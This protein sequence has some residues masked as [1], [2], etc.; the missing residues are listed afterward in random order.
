M[1]TANPYSQYLENQIKTAT[2][3]RLLVLTYDAAIRFARLAAERMKEG[4]LDEQSANIIK[5]QNI[6]L[7]LMSSLD[8]QVDRQLAANLSSLYSYAFDRLTQANIHDDTGALEEVTSLLTELR[9][10]WAQAES[11]LRT[12]EQPAV[13]RQVA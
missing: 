3:G 12:G 13:E 8:P 5:V 9:E 1:S 6:L 4:R 10:T 2:P 7:E 11:M